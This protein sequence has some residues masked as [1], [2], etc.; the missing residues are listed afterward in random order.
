MRSSSIRPG[1]LM[2]ALLLLLLL[3]LLLHARSIRRASTT[4]TQR[5]KNYPVRRKMPL[6]GCKLYVIAS[7]VS[8]MPM[9]MP[10]YASSALRFGS[11]HG[12]ASSC[13]TQGFPPAVLGAYLGKSCAA[14]PRSWRY[15]RIPLR[16]VFPAFC[17][18]V[19]VGT[20]VNGAAQSRRGVDLPNQHYFHHPPPHRPRR[21]NPLPRE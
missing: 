14:M 8:S 17:S 19:I 5:R 2:F 3:L 1:D 11:V 15:L 6:N 18:S 16:G 9:D 20:A 4:L 12:H 10:S 21:P 13:I 7:V